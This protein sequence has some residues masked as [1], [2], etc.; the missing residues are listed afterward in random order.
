MHGCIMERYVIFQMKEFHEISRPGSLFLSQ[1]LLG[2]LLTGY[3]YLP[4]E[5]GYICTCLCLSSK[6][7]DVPLDIAMQNEAV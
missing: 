3:P 4:Q 2:C 7:S 1:G 6:W 5:G